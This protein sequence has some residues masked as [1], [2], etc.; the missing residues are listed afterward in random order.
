VAATRRPEVFR[1]LIGHEPR[2]FLLLAG[3]EFEPP[4]PEVQ[5][6]I[7]VVAELLRDGEHEQ[8]AHLFVDT[9]IFGPGAWDAQLTPELRE[10]FVYNAPTFL[11][12]LNDP[13]A[14]RFDLDALAAFDR[15]ALLTSGTESASF[16]AAARAMAL[17]TTVR[18]DSGRGRHRQTATIPDKNQVK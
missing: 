9:I 3:T 11:D 16:F 4:L 15:P 10:T 14:L 17:N 6:R 13:D 1:T 5:A 12:E 8:A 2:L 7:D 18:N